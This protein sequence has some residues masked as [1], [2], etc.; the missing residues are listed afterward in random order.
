MAPV[1]SDC[2]HPE[3]VPSSVEKIK[4]SPPKSAVT[5]LK[6]SPDGAATA[7]LPLGGGI[8]PTKGTF[9]LPAGT[10]KIFP[11]P[12]YSVETPAMLSETQNGVGPCT[13]PHAL[14]RFLSRTLPFSGLPEVTRLV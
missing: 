2:C 1:P 5:P 7:L 6:P 9:L 11:L 4:R 12:S 10:V 3:I 13:R 14:S 8:V